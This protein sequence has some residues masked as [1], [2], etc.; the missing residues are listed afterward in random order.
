MSPARAAAEAAAMSPDLIDLQPT[1]VPPT[2]AQDSTGP[3]TMNDPRAAERA[4]QYPH[5]LLRQ[6]ADTVGARCPK[7]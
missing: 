3:F 6:G 7:T 4:R 1:D 5:Q 2:T